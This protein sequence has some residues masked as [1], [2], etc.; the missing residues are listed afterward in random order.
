MTTLEP[1]RV[2]AGRYRVIRPLRATSGGGVYEARQDDLGRR[3]AIKVLAD[4]RIAPAAL[5]RFRVEA[6]ATARL[7]SPH[8]VQV[9]DFQHVPG[10]PPFLVMEL[11]E[12]RTLGETLRA[13]GRMPWQRAARIGLQIL[14]A[15]EAAH[16]ARIIHRAVHPDNVFLVRSLAVTDFV[17]LLDFGGAKLLDGDAPATVPMSRGSAAPADDRTDLFGAAATL[18]AAVSGAAPSADAPPLVDVDP[19]FASIV[20]EALAS[21]PARRPP[22]AAVMAEA[23]RTRLDLAS[24]AIAAPI[25][26]A[27]PPLAPTLPWSAAPVPRTL[28][29][30]SPPPPASSNVS[31]VVSL[32]LL[33][34]VL[35]ACS[36][37]AVWYLVLAPD[38]PRP[39]TTTPAAA[40]PA[41]LTGAAWF[42]A[43]EAQARSSGWKVA[44]VVAPARD[45][46]SG[47]QIASIALS[48]GTQD[49]IVQ[50]IEIPPDN[51]ARPALVAGALGG[52]ACATTS[53]ENHVVSVCVRRPDDGAAARALLA[54]STPR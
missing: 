16:A 3:V 10:E 31:V 28:A 32:V 37:M 25:G 52:A 51:P 53:D 22:S 40:T 41:P 43:W 48:R 29:M 39:T 7:G 13:E 14:A 54:A 12:G 46:S 1:G 49:A 18:Y 15:L 24:A 38:A 30:T 50:L 34:L 4:P 9:T 6:E 42:A 20:A 2:L 21:D 23:L 44:K 27:P 26:I 17:K 36:G 5:A 45:A 11:L 8:L 35:A 19:G 33:G 47:W